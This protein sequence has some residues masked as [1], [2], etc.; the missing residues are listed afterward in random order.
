MAR[1]GIYLG[2]DNQSVSNI[3]NVLSTWVHAL[4]DAGYEVDLIGGT[5]IPGRTAEAATMFRVGKSSASTPFGKIKETYTQTT[6]YISR[7]NPKAV[8]QIWKY[9]TQALGVSLAGKVSRVPTTIR[10]SGDVFQEFQGY[11]F[12]RNAGIFFLDNVL[13]TVPLLL[14]DKIVVLGPVLRNA[15][16]SKGAPEADVHLIPP[17]RPD[18]TRFLTTDNPRAAKTELGLDPDRRTALFVGRLSS[19]KGMPF[20]QDVMESTL[21]KTDFQFVLV[22]KGPYRQKFRDRFSSRDVILPGHVSHE[23]V[24]KYYQAATVYVHP[25]QFEGIPLVILEALQSGTP[26]VARKA[27]DVG[28]VVEDVVETEQEMTEQLI[29]GKWNSVWKNE[30]LFLPDSQRAAVQ[31]LIRDIM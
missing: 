31:D 2:S 18:P 23:K 20:L 16:T 11:D 29:N 17:P 5:E 3:A 21:S 19:Q 24:A 8:M 22:G 15:I 14:A 10:F 12:P 30:K 7:A 28:F 4:S 26:V 27:G 9:Q 13:G 6:E 1:V 25:S